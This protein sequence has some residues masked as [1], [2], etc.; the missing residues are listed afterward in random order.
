MRIVKRNFIWDQ[1]LRKLIS[2]CI[3]QMLQTFLDLKNGRE[4]EKDMKPELDDWR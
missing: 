4:G 2:C 3:E 1:T